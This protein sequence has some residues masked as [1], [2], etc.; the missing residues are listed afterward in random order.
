[1]NHSNSNSESQLESQLESQV[2]SD[3]NMRDNRL[4]GTN[5]YDVL[6]NYDEVK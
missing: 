2:D 6:E 4:S 5:R 3:W 1:M